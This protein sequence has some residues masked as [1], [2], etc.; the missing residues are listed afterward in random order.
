MSDPSLEKEI[1]AH[2][3]D[4]KADAKAA[5]D[6]EERVVKKA[7]TIEEKPKELVFADDES[8]KL[9]KEA[10]EKAVIYMAKKRVTMDRGTRQE[11][12]AIDKYKRES[13]RT[14][15]DMQTWLRVF[16]C[17]HVMVIGK[18]DGIDRENEEVIEVKTR[19]QPRN[20]KKGAPWKNEEAQLRLYMEGAKLPRCRMLQY[21]NGEVDSDLVLERDSTKTQELFAKIRTHVEERILGWWKHKFVCSD[22]YELFRRYSVEA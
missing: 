19:R 16:P 11:S 10:E 22:V 15:T 12:Q 4:T 1:D 18:P 5:D 3:A 21:C 2:T 17:S 7:R 6:L 13:G 20:V 9:R 14:I 8:K